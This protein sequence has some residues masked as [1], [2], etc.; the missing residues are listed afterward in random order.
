MFTF[1]PLIL[2]RLALV[3]FALTLPA[4]PLAAE[5][6]TGRASVS[7]GDTLRMGDRRIRIHGIDAPEMDQTCTRTGGADW[8]CGRWSRRQLAALIGGARV[9]CTAQEQDRYGRLVATCIARGMDLGAEMVRHGAARAF[10]RYSSRYVPQEK[11]AIFAAR[12]LWQGDNAAPWDHRAGT[13]QATPAAAPSGC[14]IKGNISSGGRIFHVQGQENYA[15]T[16]INTAKGERWF[17]S[18]AEARAAGWRAARR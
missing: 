3:A 1:H 17:C 10:V 11:E 7:D 5:T 2:A 13:G 18:P 6:L 14:T 4:A 12:G 8:A 15:R 9:T 16:R